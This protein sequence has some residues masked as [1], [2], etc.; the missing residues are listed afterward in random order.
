MKQ[1]NHHDSDKEDPVGRV[2]G[3]DGNKSRDG[4]LQDC[5]MGGRQGREEPLNAR[6]RDD[7]SNVQLSEEADYEDASD[8][9]NVSDSLISNRVQQVLNKS[10]SLEFLLKVD[11]KI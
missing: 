7:S 2:S 6:Q 11:P 9:D 4:R 5:N 1:F 3:V 8:G 10:E